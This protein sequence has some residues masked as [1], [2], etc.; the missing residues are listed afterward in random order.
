MFEKVLHV[1]NVEGIKCEK[2]SDRIKG[3]LKNIKGVK[4]V[5]VDIEN[6]LVNAR[7]SKKVDS[8][9]LED[10]INTLGFNVVK[11]NN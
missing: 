11:G 10:T 8:K 9:T 1:Y 5:E 6:K 2:C 4:S 7:C 3:A